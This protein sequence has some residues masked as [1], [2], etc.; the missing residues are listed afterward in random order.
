MN[1]EGISLATK[2]ASF[3][4]DVR[5]FTFRNR[6]VNQWNHIDEEVISA[7]SLNTTRWQ[8]DGKD[9]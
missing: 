8:D 9:Q 6:V 2:K 3:K 1:L 5:E 4:I 7:R